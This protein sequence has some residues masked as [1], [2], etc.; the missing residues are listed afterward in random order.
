MKDIFAGIDLHRNNAVCVI[1]NQQGRRLAHRKLPNE[2]TQIQHFL[3]PYHARLAR[4]GVE[5]TFNWYWLVDGLQAAGYPVGLAHPTAMH[6]YN[7]LKHTD[8]ESD[9]A[10]VAELLRLGILPEGHI[11]D[12]ELRPV[13]DL[14]RRRLLLVR[15]RTSLLLSVKSLYARTTG[16]TLSQGEAKALRPEG[17]PQRFAHP[18][19]RLIAT[20]QVQLIGQLSQSIHR[21]E[22]A[23]DAAASELPS[24]ARLQSLPGVGRILGWTITLETAD[25]QRFASPGAYASYC[26]CVRTQRESNGKP[27]GENNGKCGNRYLAW[28]WVEATHCAIRTDAACRRFYDRKQ[29]KTN[30]M[31]ATKALACKLAKA[32]WHV[33]KHQQDYDPRRMFPGAGESPRTGPG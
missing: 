4:V 15:Q 5:A 31:V 28:A 6:Q 16:Q 23:V 17:V 33:M 30:T 12:P 1:V 32:G 2:L 8:D 7:G 13:R 9:A 11:C 24:Y 19:H 29:A 10:F 25:I 18:T 3:R 22:R 14:L 21:I 27:K 20:E 26:R